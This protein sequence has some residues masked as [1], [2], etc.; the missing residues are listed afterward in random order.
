MIVIG[1]VVVGLLAAGMYYYI[2]PLMTAS[3]ATPFKVSLE[4]IH[5]VLPKMPLPTSSTPAPVNQD[6]IDEHVT[7]TSFMAPLHTN[8]PNA[9]SNTLP[10][11]DYGTSILAN[12]LPQA[13]EDPDVVQRVRKQGWVVDLTH[14]IDSEAKTKFEC[15]HICS[16]DLFNVDA[17]V[18]EQ[19]NCYEAM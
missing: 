18:F 2:W 13:Y 7:T 12:P 3:G 9:P 19:C 4:P 14:G 17:K 15:A 11:D 16:G 5:N 1:I 8:E 6:A 10:S